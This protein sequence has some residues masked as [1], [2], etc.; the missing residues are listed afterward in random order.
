MNPR[1]NKKKTE[2]LIKKIFYGRNLFLMKFF[3]LNLYYKTYFSR[4]D[5]FFLFEIKDRS[6]KDLYIIIFLA[7]SGSNLT[8]NVTSKI[9]VK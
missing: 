8:K 3:L 7:I 6:P 4:L 1:K 2:K 9:I 5:E